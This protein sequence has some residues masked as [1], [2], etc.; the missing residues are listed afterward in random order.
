MLGEYWW[1][2]KRIPGSGRIL[3]INSDSMITVEES[4]DLGLIIQWSGV[5]AFADG[6]K[7]AVLSMAVVDLR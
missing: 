4:Q 3:Q 5:R 6:E 2:V 7:D 1:D